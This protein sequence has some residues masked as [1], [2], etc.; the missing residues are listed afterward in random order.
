MNQPLKL[1]VRWGLQLRLRWLLFCSGWSRWRVG[2]RRRRMLGH[3]MGCGIA[4]LMLCGS[5]CASRVILVH[6]SRDV[7]VTAEPVRAR[8]YVHDASGALVRSQNKVVIPA[9][10]TVLYVSPEELGKK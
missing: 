9:G 4:W 5:G 6:P 2:I 7:L 8:V 3:L 1:W 10:W